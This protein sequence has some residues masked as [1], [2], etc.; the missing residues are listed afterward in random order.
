MRKQG[1]IIGII[2]LFLGISISSSVSGN[3]VEEKMPSPIIKGPIFIIG[4][5]K[6]ISISP[7]GNLYYI[8]AIALFYI[9]HF[10]FPGLYINNHVIL[11]FNEQN[12]IIKRHFICGI[13]TEA[14]LYIYPHIILFF[15][16][17][18]I[19]NVTYAP[20]DG[21]YDFNCVFFLVIQDMRPFIKLYYNNE[22]MRLY[23]LRGFVGEQFAVTWVFGINPKY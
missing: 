18:Y 10:V 6:D 19:T 14:E 4:F 1:L 17:G 22:H 7:N 11:T 23:F 15:G 13:F 3:L 16:I 2:L 20:G 21:F 8:H 5:F 12:A 9:K